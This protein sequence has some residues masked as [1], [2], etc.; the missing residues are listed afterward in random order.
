MKMKHAH[1]QLKKVLQKKL[2]DPQFRLYF[3]ESRGIS[4]LCEAVAKARL[5][6]G[7][8]QTE[9]AKKVDTSQSVIARLEKGNQGRMPSLDLLGR[10]ATALGL[11][12]VV[13]FEKKKA[14]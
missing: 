12:L 13:G 8:N 6:R 5:A 10:I 14:A 2:K 1:L 11:N 7:L 9:L 4:D 3:E